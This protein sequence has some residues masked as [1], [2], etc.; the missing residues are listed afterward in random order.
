MSGKTR[1]RLVVP[2]SVVKVSV[3]VTLKLI[4]S[5]DVLVIWKGAIAPVPSFSAEIARSSA[6]KALS[7]DDR[8]ERDLEK[9]ATPR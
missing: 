4:V 8:W 3:A 5:E 1:R 9:E 7:G 6:Q 2:A